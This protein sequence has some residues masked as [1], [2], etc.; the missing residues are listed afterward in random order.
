MIRTIPC[1]SD[2]HSLQFKAFNWPLNTVG[3]SLVWPVL[4]G[5]RLLQQSARFFDGPTQSEGAEEEQW[6][7]DASY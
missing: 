1:D 2:P 5:T 3:D 6:Q 7:A 4:V